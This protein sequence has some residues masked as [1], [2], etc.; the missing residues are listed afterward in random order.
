MLEPLVD[1]LCDTNFLIYLATKRIKNLDFIN[2]EIGQID[3]IIPQVVLTELKKLQEN[4][5][6]QNDIIRT[7]DFV[8][9]LKII[10]IN[11]KYADKEILEYVKKHG[12][13]VGTLDKEL[14]KQIK[15]ANG[16]ILSLSNNRIILES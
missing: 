8:K 11:G 13:I 9:K 4:P 3:F 7:L 2:E 1:V 10:P 16:S 6:K 12:G 14:K 15:K 5:S